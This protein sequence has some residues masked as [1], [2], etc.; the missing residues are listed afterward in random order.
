[1]SKPGFHDNQV[2]DANKSNNRP[3]H[4]EWDVVDYVMHFSYYF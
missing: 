1:M 2:G 3:I 4:V